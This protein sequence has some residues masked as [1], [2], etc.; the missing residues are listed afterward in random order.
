MKLA[1]EILNSLRFATI[2]A[3]ALML[4]A[5]ATAPS[6]PEDRADFE[7]INDPAEPT[8]R[9]IFN[10]NMAI[11]SAVLKPAAEAYR[12]YVPKPA[13]SGLR[14]A[15]TNLGE[16]VVA[17]NDLLQANPKKAWITVQRFAVNSTLG[18]GGLFD[19]AE[20]WGLPHHDSDFGQTFGVWGIGEGPF[21]ELPLFGPSNPR[22]AVGLALNFVVDPFNLAVGPPMAYK[23]AKGGTDALDQR[24]Q[25][26]S[27]IDDLKRNSLDFYAS[28]RSAYRQRRQKQIDD[29][30]GGTTHVE[31]NRPTVEPSKP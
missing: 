9:A 22:D 23:L 10:T 30:A 19:V 16:P 20:D 25:N 2:V 27:A 5:C 3:A 17:F 13:Q 28:V 24:A 21:I 11:D 7:R 15:F 12:D 26:I 18:L 6:D 29:A 8:N 1:C 4:G 31:V 14:N